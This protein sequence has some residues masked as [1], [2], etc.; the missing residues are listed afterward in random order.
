METG[1]LKQRLLVFGVVLLVVFSFVFTNT[2]PISMASTPLGS[3][4]LSINAGGGLNIL[5]TDGQKL[6]FNVG[7]GGEQVYFATKAHYCCGSDSGSV[8]FVL[9]VGSSTYDDGNFAANEWTSKNVLAMSGS[10]SMTGGTATG[11]GYALV[12]YT[13][14]SGGLTYIVEREII[15]TSPNRFFLENFTVT[16]PAGNTQIVRLYRG[17][18][19][20]PGGSDRGKG[21]QVTSPVETV[22]SV[23]PNSKRILGFRE[24][25]NGTF[26]GRFT[27]LYNTSSLRNNI[28]TGNDLG[29]TID[30]AEQ[31]TELWVQSP[32]VRRLANTPNHSTH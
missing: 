31:D 10:A 22:L 1:Y 17:G 23:E 29:S 20:Y 19:T 32:L 9:G 27:G 8:S 11:N 15:Y 5:G 7:G 14:V 13:A 12:E 18:D 26:S 28:R 30:P 2:A 6:L 4:T 16:V 25:V 24:V 21:A 3:S